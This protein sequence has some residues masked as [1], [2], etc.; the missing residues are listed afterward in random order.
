MQPYAYSVRRP[1]EIEADFAIH[2]LGMLV[3]AIG[4]AALLGLTAASTDLTTFSSVLA[5]TIALIAMLGFSAAYNLHR[6]SE[7][8]ELLRRLDH[9]AIFTMIAGTYTPFT[10]RIFDGAGAAW[11]TGSIWAAALA[12]A[13]V[14]LAYRHRFE[15]VSVLLHLALGWAAVVFMQPLL[16]SLDRPTVILIVLGGVVYSIGAGVHLWHRLPFHDAIWH[17]LVLIAA[18]CHYTAILHGVVLA[19]R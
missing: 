13:A 12:G 9:A 3:G 16:A 14:K 10:A 6:T 1:E 4:A 8:R 15:G 19:A 18:S 2:L 7:R 11:S 5:Y 17:G